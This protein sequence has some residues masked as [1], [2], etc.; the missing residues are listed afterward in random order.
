MIATHLNPAEL[1]RFCG[2]IP[3]HSEQGNFGRQ[4]GRMLADR[5]VN[6]EFLAVLQQEAGLVSLGDPKGSISEFRH[7]AGSLLEGWA[8]FFI[9]GR[10]VP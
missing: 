9:G 2:Q 6:R 10:Q 8:A 4:Q 1:R 5:T 3:Y 7:L